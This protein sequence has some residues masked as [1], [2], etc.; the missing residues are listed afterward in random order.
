M[1]TFSCYT[2]LMRG[3]EV[4]KFAPG[5]EVPKWALDMVGEHVLTPLEDPTDDEVS[6]EDDSAGGVDDADEEEVEAEDDK[7]RVKS[8]GKRGRGRNSKKQDPTKL[9]FTHTPVKK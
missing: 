4:H 6:D 9:D 1:R 2:A 5:D 8:T 7:P 3:V